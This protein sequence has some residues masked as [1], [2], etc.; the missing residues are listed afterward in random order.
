MVYLEL[1]RRMP[2]NLAAT[3]RAYLRS[4]AYTTRAVTHTAADLN[5]EHEKL[6]TEKRAEIQQLIQ[7]CES[8][9]F[10]LFF[11]KAS[12]S[13]NWTNREFFVTEEELTCFSRAG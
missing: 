2:K 3:A 6:M 7:V 5:E 10:F 8:C 11:A 4:R 9:F 1:D 13:Q 12:K